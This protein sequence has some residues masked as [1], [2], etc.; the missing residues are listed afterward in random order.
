MDTQLTKDE[1][2][3][4]SSEYDIETGGE[5]PEQLDQMC[6]D[7][8]AAVYSFLD[9]TPSEEWTEDNFRQYIEA[10]ADAQS[11]EYYE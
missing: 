9:G 10:W 3:D 7:F 6:D 11:E 2:L 5:T 1:I 4:L 8:E